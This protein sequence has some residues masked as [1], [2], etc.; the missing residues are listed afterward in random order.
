M[1][2]VG[3]RARAG[4]H[5][6]EGGRQSQLGSSDFHKSKVLIS[7]EKPGSKWLE[8]SRLRIH[9]TVAFHG[10]QKTASCN[11]CGKVYQDG[12]STSNLARHV[13]HRHTAEYKKTVEEHAL[14]NTAHSAT[15]H[16]AVV[17]KPLAGTHAPPAV[18]GQTDNLSSL[19]ISSGRYFLPTGCHACALE[20]PNFESDICQHLENYTHNLDARLG[21]CEDLVARSLKERLLKSTHINIQL[22][23]MQNTRGSHVAVFASFAPNLTDSEDS[24]PLRQDGLLLANCHLLDIL[25]LGSNKEESLSRKLYDTFKEFEIA[26]KVGTITTDIATSMAIMRREAAEPL[27]T[28]TCAHGLLSVLFRC[29]FGELMRAP[30]FSTAF[31]K[32]SD[33]AQK[34]VA[35]P[36]LKASMEA[37]GVPFPFTSVS[38]DS[39]HEWRMTKSFLDNQG[40]YLEWLSKLSV[41]P[42]FT[43]TACTL[44]QEQ[45]NILKHFV[46]CLSIF[47]V[48][49]TKLQ[50]P[51]SN[52]IMNAVL[53]FY[54]LERFYTS[55]RSAVQRPDNEHPFF[56]VEYGS[57]REQRNQVLQGVLVSQKIFEAQF[58]S[59]KR[60]PLYFA[61]AALNPVSKFETFRELMNEAECSSRINE[62]ESFF[63]GWL[64]GSRNSRLLNST[65]EITISSLTTTHIP[66]SETE[67]I[68][69]VDEWDF[70]KREPKLYGGSE[71]DGVKW[72]Y[73]HRSAYPQLFK[74]AVAL[75]Y[76]KI[77]VR[78]SERL[79]SAKESLR[80]R[81]R[82]D[83]QNE[84]LKRLVILR[85]RLKSFRFVRSND[86][87]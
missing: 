50:N 23:L 46:N 31:T 39:V 58:D 76:T 29:I 32:I 44:S 52:T 51:S 80:R 87:L 13:T 35:T 55:A 45:L 24:E 9:F 43:L 83:I 40:K 8:R 12:D 6:E 74:L 28:I 68:P 59:F 18:I 15:R 30:V 54:S 36:N 20:P 26:D 17:T 5:S 75:Y 60:N 21:L 69:V 67:Q 7:S 27:P 37:F 16:P 34:T 14:S 78:G 77:S 63:H 65:G 38:S 19:L 70:Y 11:Y 66:D 79:F 73:D 85:D 72:W 33:F 49:A 47:E 84:N 1:E 25:E 48:W 56:P 62:L 2:S 41:N 71:I 42:A 10:D 53:V 86:Q 4:S 3:K 61:A 64:S 82:Q 22:E 57:S 81:E